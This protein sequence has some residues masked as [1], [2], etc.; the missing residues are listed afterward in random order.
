MVDSHLQLSASTRA[1]PKGEGV[2]IDHK[3]H[4]YHTVSIT[5]PNRLV[6]LAAPHKSGLSNHKEWI[7]T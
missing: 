6:R 7:I 2:V 3:S 4:G 1:K 5:Y